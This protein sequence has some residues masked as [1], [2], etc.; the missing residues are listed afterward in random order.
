MKSKIVIDACCHVPNAH[1]KGRAI[2]GNSACG[3]LI[4]NEYGDEKEYSKFLGEMTPPEAEFNGLIFALD[5][6]VDLTTGEVQIWMDNE[7]VIK[8]MKKEY[9]M[10]KPHIRPLFDQAKK[11]EARYKNIEYFWHPET[12]PLAQRVHKI[13]AKEYDK[14]IR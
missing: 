1:I 14:N 4:I 5:N 3:V 9:R 6:G 12:A 13:A 11:F 2:K 10:H 7:L 8:W